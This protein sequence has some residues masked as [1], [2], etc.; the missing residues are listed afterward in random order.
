MQQRVDR[1]ADRHLDPQTRRQPRDSGG[2]GHPL[3]DRAAIAKHRIET[4]PATERKPERIIARL[5]GAT[6]QHE[7]A[8]P[9]EAS[10][11]P[12]AAALGYPQPD[13]L[14]EA[15]GDQSSPSVVAQT[16]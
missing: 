16:P 2:G 14:G 15:A 5:G 3:D 7:I 4:L 8:E 6:S 10:E 9:G 13:H 1:L 12:G 11:R